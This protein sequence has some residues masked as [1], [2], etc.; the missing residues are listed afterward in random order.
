MSMELESKIKAALADIDSF[1][2]DDCLDTD[3]IGHYV[4]N[5]LDDQGREAVEKHLHSCLYCLKQLNDM[6]ALQH[7][8]RQ[9]VTKRH[10]EQQSL[11]NVL[12]FVEKLREFFN[13][14]V[15]PCRFSA[16]GLAT[17]WVIFIA[18][19]FVLRQAGHEA[20]FPQLNRD[21][22][23]KVQALNEAGSILAEQQGVVVGS[24]GL[25]ASSLSHLAG[26]S[27]LRITLKDGSTRDISQI[28]KDE[29]KNLAVLKTDANALTSI[30]LGEI[31]EIVGKKIYAVADPSSSNKG[32]QEALASDIKEFPSHKKDGGA[33]YIQVATQSV[34]A[35][36]GAIVDD[37]GRLLGFMITEEKHIN[38]ATPVGDVAKLVKSGKAIPVSQLK[39]VSFSG[40]ALNA[41]MKGIMARDSQRWDEAISSLQTAI[42]LNP[43][44]E[45]A[46]V[47]LGYAYYRKQDFVNEAKAYEEALKINPD[48]PDALYSLAWNMESRGHYRQAIPLYEKALSLAPE[49][50]EIIY[51][52]GLSYLAQGKK[53][54]ATVMS[55]RLKR[56][57]PGLAELLR[58]LIK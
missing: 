12:T 21:A 20:G 52:L 10:K 14:T 54:M 40:D 44:L 7:F 56:L 30:P 32:L 4:E 5:T 15:N 3:L 18:S 17:A 57:D 36:K 49:D 34:T 38:L 16:I 25:I 55:E 19:S 8:Q 39:L 47:E 22:F 46:Y 26:A 37:K 23:V 48:N 2:T 6:T 53:D 42:R 24:D 45:G 27:K 31:T 58:R 9:A 35:T 33:K 43:R 51:Q 13:F 28:W 41:Y 11:A 29:N 1:Q 50:A